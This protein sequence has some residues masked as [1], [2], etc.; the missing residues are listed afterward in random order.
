MNQGIKRWAV[1]LTGWAFIG[2]GLVGL[3]LPVLQGM[4]FLAIGLVI[5]S[6]EYVWAHHLLRRLREKFPA[7]ARHIDHATERLRKWRSKA[8]TDSE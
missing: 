1:I 8:A 3:V 4:L 7:A 6:T 2:L 5:L